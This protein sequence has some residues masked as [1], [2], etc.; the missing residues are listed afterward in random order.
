[1]ERSERR[2]FTIA[3]KSDPRTLRRGGLGCELDGEVLGCSGSSASCSRYLARRALIT[4]SMQIVV[5]SS[6]FSGVS[7][8]REWHN[9]PITIQFVR[10]ERPRLETS[11][12]MGKKYGGKTY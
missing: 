12:E 5:S 11:L 10:Q 4:F 2:V 6:I 8:R 7:R 9:F 3:R 1:V